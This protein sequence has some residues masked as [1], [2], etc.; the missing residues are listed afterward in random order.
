METY[1]EGQVHTYLA[2]RLI[3]IMSSL[4][5]AIEVVHIISETDN[6]SRLNT[7][8]AFKNLTFNIASVCLLSIWLP[9]W[10]IKEEKM[11]FKSCVR[12]LTN[13][14]M[15][16]GEYIDSISL[17]VFALVGAL[18][19]FVTIFSD[20]LSVIERIA[21]GFTICNFFGQF[22]LV[23]M[24]SQETVG[25][26]RDHWKN[27]MYYASAL[28]ICFN[29]LLLSEAF[30]GPLRPNRRKEF[31]KKH[32]AN[33]VLLLTSPFYTGFLSTVIV[34]FMRT[35]PIYQNTYPE[36]ATLSKNKKVNWK[37]LFKSC[38]KCEIV[39]WSIIILAPFYTYLPLAS[40][41]FII[42]TETGSKTS[43]ELITVFYTNRLVNIF[44]DFAL[45][46]CTLNE[47]MKFKKTPSRKWNM[48]DYFLYIF[49]WFALIF[50]FVFGAAE[51][52]CTFLKPLKDDEVERYYALVAFVLRLTIVIQMITQSG[53]LFYISTEEPL[54][55]VSYKS[56]IFIMSANV[57]F[58]IGSS[59][60][61][62]TSPFD[63]S[64]VIISVYGKETTA[65]ITR[66][67][68]TF[69]GLFQLH[70][71]KMIM[72]VLF[73][74]AMIEHNECGSTEAIHIV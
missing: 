70:S 20:T 2:R 9:Y 12:F 40:S 19:E 30:I 8:T 58:W 63:F 46:G 43:E 72:N 50:N 28:L 4:G 35:W 33:L 74:K 17:G 54:S 42:D 65:V 21:N 47:V 7:I 53:F 14:K 26:K 32:W 57:C 15:N 68:L 29:S 11:I 18:R 3:I 39:F 31:G 34:T 6:E 10:F 13:V 27:W 44:L 56:L 5:V 66:M 38:G 48:N 45:V 71:G 37:S 52:Q 73:K 60:Y 69:S 41:T 24:L 51:F 36:N 67:D 22:I 62:G 1:S 61:A 16:P 59:I 55:R 25:F 49:L 64:S 23:L